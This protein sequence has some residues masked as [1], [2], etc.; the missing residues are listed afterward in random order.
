MEKN[1]PDIYTAT[2]SGIQVFEMIVNDLIVM[3]RRS[4][5]YL[6]A[7]QILK[8]CGIEKGKRTKILER[9]IIPNTHEKIQGGYGKYQGTWVP[10][11]S[12]RELA[13]RYKV[14]D[15][16]LPLIEFDTSTWDELPEKEHIPQRIIRRPTPSQS[17][18]PS[19]PSYS[20]QQTYLPFSSTSDTNNSS[21]PLKRK[22]SSFDVDDVSST[23]SLPIT[24][25]KKPKQKQQYN[26]NSNNN[27]SSSSNNN[28]NNNSSSS[29]NNKNNNSNNSNNNNNN[30]NNIDNTMLISSPGRPTIISKK[31]DMED[32]DSGRF[33]KSL[34]S[35]F[36]S[37]EEDQIPSFLRGAGATTG[38]DM[39]VTIDDQ[40]HTA[41]HW[42][43]SLARIHTAEWLISKGA[44][45]SK[46]NSIGQTPLMRGVM[47]THIHD[48]E[49]FPHM[50]DILR[51]SI[52]I[53]DDAGRSVL[54]HIILGCLESKSTATATISA[55]S[56]SSSSY[57]LSSS[58]STLSLDP[59][60]KR[61]LAAKTYMS[62]VL[63]VIRQYR[64]H[65]HILHKPDDAGESPFALASRL[66]CLD[67]CHLL[68]QAGC[69]VSE[70]DEY[71]TL[72][73]S[74]GGTLS[75]VEKKPVEKQDDKA[76]STSTDT[77]EF[78]SAKGQELISTV[79]RIVEA[80]DNE[81]KNK[82]QTKEA[83]MLRL[84]QEV[85]KL[86][87]QLT[88]ER[89]NTRELKRKNS[90][91]L[92]RA[93][94][95]IKQLESKLMKSGIN[96][97]EIGSNEGSSGW[98]SNILDKSATTLAGLDNMTQREHQLEQHIQELKEQLKVANDKT[99]HMATLEQS[100]SKSLE[101]EQECKRLISACIH[102]PMDKIDD[103]IGPLTLAIEN[104]P[105]DLDFARVIGFME[106]LRQHQQ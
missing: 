33:R 3:R 49:C 82:L 25:K 10:L 20:S 44:S 58:I 29:S 85:R 41:L 38:M 84:Q 62:T 24:V 8:L 37:A 102:L 103:F 83:N 86:S 73:S 61:L 45:I 50:L 43:V 4:D 77:N 1:K 51:D 13:D 88:D 96:D 69:L 59:A 54:H 47:V 34:M 31:D 56:S 55:P 21:Q 65:I 104:D 26:D 7:T 105:P 39:D 11:D 92:K 60:E 67:L 27:S 68:V 78:P 89:K 17:S 6:N 98:I 101:K 42:S 99:Q 9:E 64:E 16:L 28:N 5:S 94:A 36:L 81:F 35:I 76:G 74:L 30:N 95:K 70:R 79:Q 23:S 32:S 53:V 71:Y 66:K 72:S 80:M 52:S 2:Y 87:R 40:G 15:L 75:Q 63:K 106:K 97:L 100:Y 14:L 19:S 91:Q 18:P 93:D 57:Y 90:E 22:I 12:G 48:N 46:V